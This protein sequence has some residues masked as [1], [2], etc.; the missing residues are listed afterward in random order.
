MNILA[1]LALLVALVSPAGAAGQTTPSSVDQAFD[2]YA[3]AWAEPDAAA[4]SALLA[5]VWA[6]NGQ[7]KDPTVDLKGVRALSA[8]I[9]EFLKQYPAAKLTK[10]SKTDVYGSTFR[11]SWS[12]K[13]GDGKTPDLEGFDYGELDKNGRIVKIA[14]FFGPLPNEGTL[15]NEAI[16]G[17]YLDSLFTKFDYAG[18]DSVLAA[19][20]VYTQAV[21][22]PY[23]GIYHGL[24]EMMKMFIKSS[25]YSSMVVL[26]GWTFSANPVTH[27]IIASFTVRVTAKKSGRVLDMAIRECFQVRDGKIVSIMPFY[28]DTK[29][30]VEFLN[31]EKKAA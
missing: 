15:R 19:D 11:A 31:E 30:F 12:L 2:Q 18:L 24:P 14:G 16:V 20:I 22:L 23:G 21:G 27:E 25:E 17:K 5:P 13:F 6:K 3:R 1:S 4:R 7:Y 8:H 28:F 29:T 26:D 10:T 9:G